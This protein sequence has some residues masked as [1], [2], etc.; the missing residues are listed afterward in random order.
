MAPECDANI[1]QHFRDKW[2]VGAE[3]EGAFSLRV[4][5]FMTPLDLAWM[6][7]QERWRARF[8]EQKFDDRKR[9]SSKQAALRAWW[10][11]KCKQ[12]NTPFWKM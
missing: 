1:A 5:K 4:R 12:T 3:A 11:M 9:M 2:E 8:C 10:G 6:N 7:L